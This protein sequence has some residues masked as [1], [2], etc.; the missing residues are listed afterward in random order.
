MWIPAKADRATDLPPCVRDS[1]MSRADSASEA[2]CRSG[3]TEGGVGR[4]TPGWAPLCACFRF[5][6]AEG[7]LRPAK[8]RDSLSAPRLPRAAG[9]GLPGGQGVVGS[10]P[11]V[12][13]QVIAGFTPVAPAL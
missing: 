12:P 10:N 9:R 5:F 7:G 6:V 2:Q 4:G 13:T 8:L 1:E 3:S 11:A